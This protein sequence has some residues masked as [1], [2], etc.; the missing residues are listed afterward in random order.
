MHSL[1]H[2]RRLRTKLRGLLAANAAIL[3]ALTM[4]PI[5]FHMDLYTGGAL[6]A[7]HVQPKLHEYC[8]AYQCSISAAKVSTSYALQG[9]YALC[10]TM[11]G[12]IA[13]LRSTLLN[14][15]KPR[16]AGAAAMLI[17]TS[18]FLF[19]DASTIDGGGLF[20]NYV[21]RNA[22]YLFHPTVP[23]LA[24][25]SL[26]VMLCWF[27]WNRDALTEALRRAPKPAT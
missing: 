10:L 20:S 4:V 24:V 17:I 7:L 19:D 16:I 25:T 5:A 6:Q 2:H 18:V 1:D 22:A 26:A 15:R 12:G 21:H 23:F 14:E 13:A 3:A 11:L 8:L 9:A 27:A